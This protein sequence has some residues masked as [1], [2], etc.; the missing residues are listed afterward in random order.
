MRVEMLYLHTKGMKL[1]LPVCGC[2]VAASF[3][4]TFRVNVCMYVCMRACMQVPVYACRL[5]HCKLFLERRLYARMHAYTYTCTHACIQAKSCDQLIL[6][7]LCIMYACMHACMYACKK[8]WACAARCLP[9]CLRMHAVHACVSRTKS[10]WQL[11]TVSHVPASCI[12]T[13]P[14]PQCPV[15]PQALVCSSLFAVPCLWLFLCLLSISPTQSPSKPHGSCADFRFL[16]LC[17]CV[18]VCLCVSALKKISRAFQND[19]TSFYVRLLLHA[20]NVCNA[21]WVML[22]E[23][24]LYV[25]MYVCIHVC[26]QRMYACLVSRK[27]FFTTHTYICLVAMTAPTC[28]HA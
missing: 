13:M 16:S 22:H 12:H 10:V 4:L 7:G 18:C 6:L 11:N 27:I 26:L 5:A 15:P 28:I 14:M 25:Y 20:C 23:R 2:S 1:P 21:M 17:V 24:S 19:M 9:Q 8:P 3:S